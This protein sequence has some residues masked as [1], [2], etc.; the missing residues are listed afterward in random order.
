MKDC[1]KHLSIVPG[2][3]CYCRDSFRN[4]AERLLDAFALAMDT[5]HLI[6][7]LW[8]HFLKCTAATSSYRQYCLLVCME[9]VGIQARLAK[10]K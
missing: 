1:C 5:S 3:L 9:A 4:D 2:E 10:T 7:R 6:V 8:V